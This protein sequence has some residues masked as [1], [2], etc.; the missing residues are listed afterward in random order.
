VPITAISVGVGLT[1]LVNALFGG[2]AATVA[3]TGAAILAGP[4]AGRP[5]GRYWASII[6]AALTV[7]VALG[8][9]TLASLVSYLP[10]TFVVTLAGL[11]ILSSLQSALETAFKGGLKFGALAAL[12]VAATPF[13]LFG[14]T[15][16]LWAILAGLAASMMA[17]RGELRVRW[18]SGETRREMRDVAVP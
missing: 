4:D 3:R 12:A 17:E 5:A 11:A 18:R 13:T 8:A 1:S 14:I 10:R 15:S 16:A 6:A 9:G 7:F 2:H